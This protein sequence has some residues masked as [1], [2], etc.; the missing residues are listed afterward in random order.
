MDSINQKLEPKN[1]EILIDNLLQN[2]RNTV[3]HNYLYQLDMPSLP[4]CC[5]NT[6]NNLIVPESFKAIEDII[7]KS[8]NNMQVWQKERQF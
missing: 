6:Y 3:I 8:L 5:V 2:L 1:F 7:V 4:A